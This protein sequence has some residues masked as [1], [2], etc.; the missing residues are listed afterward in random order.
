MKTSIRTH[1]FLRLL[2]VLIIGSCISCLISILQQH[3]AHMTVERFIP[4]LSSTATPAHTLTWLN[5]ALFS[6][7]ALCL[8]SLFWFIIGRSLRPM[9]IL[10]EEFSQHTPGTARVNM[11]HIPYEIKPLMLEVN[12][13]FERISETM[14]R[15]KRF[16]ADAA[17]ELRTP[18]AV[19]S[20][21]AQIALQ[22]SDSEE[23]K[24]AL[25]RILAGV[26]RSGHVVHQLLTLSRMVPEAVIQEPSIFNLAT[27]ATEMI[28]D[29]YSLAQTKDIELELDAPEEDAAISGNPI[30]ISIL[31]RNLIDN[32]LR[33][34]P[35]HGKVIVSIK[36]LKQTRQV[37]M[38]VRDTG[39][40][41]PEELRARVFERFFRVDGSKTSGSGLGLSIVQQI[42]K[43]HSGSMQLRSPQDPPGDPKQNRGL[44][45]YMLFPLAQK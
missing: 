31:L 19:M 22:A 18:L 15:E 30:A 1:I 29:M 45:I 43:L 26:K 32:G 23:R 13:L 24:Q 16:A 25:T 42:V 20:A 12:K 3:L 17:H 40:G 33:Y 10:A 9:R 14:Q 21:Q 4:S 2:V 11:Q 5:I 34:S 44:E 37:A 8:A 28:V 7:L 35:T 38:I 39:P 41:I 36:L 6:I 27:P